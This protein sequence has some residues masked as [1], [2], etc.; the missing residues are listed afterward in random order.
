MPSALIGGVSVSLL[1]AISL[2]AAI[3]IGGL[4]WAPFGQSIM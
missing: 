3:G 4:I 2:P 1:L